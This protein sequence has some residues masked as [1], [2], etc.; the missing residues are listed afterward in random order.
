M[1][2]VLIITSHFPPSNLAGV[3]RGRLFAKYLPNYG[4][5]PI[6]LTVDEKYYEEKLD[7]DLN[8]LVPAGLQVEKVNAFNNS[9]PRTIG[10]LGLRSFFQL[11]KRANTLIEN[12]KI[13]FVYIIIP[14]F[15]LSLLGRF[16][17][18]KH[19]IKYGID[20]MD[21]WVHKFPGSDK[22]FSRHWFST[23]L[24]KLLEP[25]SLKNVSL[26]TSVAPKY[27]EPIFCRN[28]KLTHSGVKILSLPMGWDSDEKIIVERFKNKVTRFTNS[29]KYTLVYAG[30]FLPHAIDVITMFFQVIQRNRN[31][32]QDVE[33]HFI[34]TGHQRVNGVV[35]TIKDIAQKM[36]IFN[37]IVFEHP[38]RIPYL[39]VLNHISYS[40]GILIVGSSESHYTPS[41]LFSAF[42]MNKPVFAILHEQSTAL[43]IVNNTNWGEVCEYSDANFINFETQVIN[44]FLLWKQKT[45]NKSWEFDYQS[46]A[47]LSIQSITFQLSKVFDETVK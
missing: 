29:K 38:D 44:K 39:N 43:T 13:D 5:N 3:H 41:K 8:F 22:I 4:W 11:L 16:L 24:S 6:V 14:S 34:G 33:F 31:L 12:S 2:N 1:K 47:H 7:Y 27:I 15:Y 18:R 37:D 9:T 26:L 10:D 23:V 30:A 17:Y 35:T 19:G 32:F 25:I 21:P 46:A 36:Q 20:Y 42:I 45:V 28:P 40:S